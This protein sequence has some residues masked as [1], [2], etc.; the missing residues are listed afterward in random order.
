MIRWLR[1]QLRQR[2][3]DA[4]WWLVLLA[5]LAIDILATPH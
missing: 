3:H 5:W 4:P 2:E 1:D